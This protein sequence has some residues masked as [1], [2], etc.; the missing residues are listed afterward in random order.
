MLRKISMFKESNIYTGIHKN[1]ITPIADLLFGTR[2]DYY[3]RYIK[4]MNNFSK[5]KINAW[6]NKMLRQL[7]THAYENTEYYRILF[8]RNNINP[9]SI[10]TKSDLKLIPSLTKEDIRNNY[11]SLIPE[12]IDKIK[13]LKA[14]TGGSTGVPLKYLLDIHTWSFHIANGIVNWQRSGYNYGDK[15]LALGS[16]SLF[17]NKSQPFKIWMY[18]KLKRKI[19]LC[20]IV[21]S[22]KI[23]EEYLDIINKHNVTFIYGYASSIFLLA[24]YAIKKNI[25]IYIRAC[26]PTSEILTDNYRSTI[27]KAFNCEVLNSYGARDGGISSFEHKKG[28]HEVS[29]NSIVNLVDVDNS[30]IGSSSLTSLLNLAM[31]LINYDHG[32]AYRINEERNKDYP[33]NG[34]I[35]NEI[36]GR[37]S[38]VIRL[39]N[40]NVLTGPGFTILFR[41][42]PVEKYSIEIDKDTS[43]LCKI[44]KL[45]DYSESDE[46]IIIETISKHAGEGIT[47]KIEY[48]EDFELTNSGKRSYFFVK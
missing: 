7:I 4:K 38:D 13:H 10:K 43:I 20:G 25:E 21:M 27:A 29:Y 9:Y 6:Q 28:F 5:Q 44:K 41:D 16:T 36:I 24:K 32:D 26:F 34:Q 17:V 22:D 33:Y 39:V 35:I 19:G 31:P 23:C 30:N 42:L 37:T 11:N 18:Y 40:G 47:I 12:N 2:V 48:V 46:K 8:D 15:Y 45:P 1:Y 3:C 14:S